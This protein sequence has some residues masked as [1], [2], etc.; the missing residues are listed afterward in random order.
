MPAIGRARTPSSNAAKAPRARFGQ[1]A[2]AQAVD[3]ERH[4]R[5]LRRRERGG[6]AR[7][8]RG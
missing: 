6:K 4:Q 2:H 8:Q 7:V 5:H 3:D 1:L